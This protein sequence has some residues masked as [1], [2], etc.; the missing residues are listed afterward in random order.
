MG[1]QGWLGGG[2]SGSPGG[3][4]EACCGLPPWTL[5]FKAGEHLLRLM[6]AEIKPFDF[7]SV[8]EQKKAL[9]NRC[10]DESAQKNYC[11]KFMQYL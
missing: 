9:R 1:G 10:A 2:A 7:S 5:Y 4:S 8:S 6:G 3:I 11:S